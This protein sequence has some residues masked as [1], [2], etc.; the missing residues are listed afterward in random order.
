MPLKDILQSLYKKGDVMSPEDIPPPIITLTPSPYANWVL[1]GGIV[2]GRTYQIQGPPSGGK[3]MFTHAICSKLLNKDDELEVII[4]YDVELS[5][6]R[7]WHHVFMPD[8][9]EER[10]IL[11]RS[12]IASE[13]FDHITD[14]VIPVL[15][16]EKG[17][18]VKAIVIDSLQSL[19]PPKIMNRESTEDAQYAALAGF[20]PDALTGILGP[21]RKYNIPL[22]IVSQV[23][24]NM[25]PSAKY[26]HEK[27]KAGAGYA[28]Q[29]AIDVDLLFEMIESKDSKTFD[30]TIKNAN[31]NEVRTGHRVR[32]TNKKNKVS[33][34]YRV[35]EFQLDYQK[36]IVNT[37]EEIAKL[38]LN[39]GII[40]VEGNTYSFNGQKI[41]V[42]AAKTLE[43]IASSKAIQ[44]AIIEAVEQSDKKTGD[45]K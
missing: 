25:D 37:E 36:G 1:S 19:R 32:I 30:S 16:E 29:H 14:V 21:V 8:I 41:A 2:S 11:K 26:T 6:A 40:T 43:V 42:G 22:L 12:N 15:I 45:K 23:R 24:A 4:W 27:F 3:S 38:G 35:G 20:L 13:V 44:E 34:P 18:K 5:Y 39:L 10:I 7:H 17:L 9:P 28:W 33:A 31:D